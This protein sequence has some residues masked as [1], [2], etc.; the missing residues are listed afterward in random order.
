MCIRDRFS[1]G[2]NLGSK[3]LCTN[4]D[5]I[6]FE[7]DSL[8]NLLHSCHRW[9]NVGFENSVYKFGQDS[10]RDWL[11]NQSFTCV[12]ACTRYRES[13]N[14]ASFSSGTNLGSKIQCMFLDKIHFETDSL[15]NLLYSWQHIHD[16]GRVP[17]TH[18]F[19]LVQIWA[20][21]FG[22]HF[23]TRLISRQTHYSICYMCQCLHDI[24]RVGIT[25]YFLLV[26]IW[27]Q[28]FCVPIWA[29]KIH[30]EGDSLINL[31]HSCHI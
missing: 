17:I 30:F 27:V 23:W 26:Q 7:S 2:T 13:R 16:I 21:K 25:Y 22:V 20:Q 9:Y 15:I 8:I 5:K 19:L 24:G 11:I 18:Y 10:F 31:L 12:N 3:F 29:G 14:H 6:H 28:K 4:L 1:S